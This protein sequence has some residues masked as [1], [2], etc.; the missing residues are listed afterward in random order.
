MGQCFIHVIRSCPQA[1]LS[2]S[3]TVAFDMAD[4]QINSRMHRTLHVLLEVNIFSHSGRARHQ[5]CIVHE[6][7]KDKHRVPEAL[8]KSRVKCLIS[9]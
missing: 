7:Q 3:A 9:K 5:D 1:F 6:G 8:T 2:D 4:S